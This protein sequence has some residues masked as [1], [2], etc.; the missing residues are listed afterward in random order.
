MT[1]SEFENWHT[2]RAAAIR[3]HIEAMTPEK[4]KAYLLDVAGYIVSE[5]AYAEDFDWSPT[6][7]LG[8]VL[9]KHLV[10]AYKSKIE[11]LEKRIEELRGGDW[12]ER[13]FL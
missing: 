3:A 11:E 5:T 12:N 1:D 10:R 6:L 13:D 2:E 4:A 9:E 7:H 8:D